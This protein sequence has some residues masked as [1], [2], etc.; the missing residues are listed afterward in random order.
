MTTTHRAAAAAGDA[1]LMLRVQADER[2]AFGELYD[3]FG[4]RAYRYAYAVARDRRAEDILQEAFLSVWRSRGSFRPEYGEVGP[5][6][7]G[8]VRQRAIDWL[9]HNGRHDS[10]RA[11]V[12]QVDGRHSAPGSVEETIAERDAAARLRG[13]LARL[14]AAQRDV[15]TLAYFGE[16][17]TTEIATAL[18]LPLGTVKGRMRLGLEKLRDGVTA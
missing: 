13:T 9:R 15:I 8:I 11:G 5:W 12:E 10:R 18:R 7:M 6:I 16:M 3:R 4:A 17:T 2:D 1:E 14:P